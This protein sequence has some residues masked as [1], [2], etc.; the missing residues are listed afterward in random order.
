MAT[1]AGRTPQREFDVVVLGAT[2][3]TGR[4]V[5]ERLATD[6]G[7]GLR[8]AIAGR[9]ASKLESLTADLAT[10]ACGLPAA[11]VV[12]ATD[13]EGLRKLAE[14]TRVICT[15]VGPY[16]QHGA[17]VVAACAATGTHYCDLAGEAHWVRDMIDRYHEQAQRTG[18][19]IVPCC[20]F[21]SIP[22]DLGVW[23]LQS[24][25]SGQGR[26]A[27]EVL[28]LLTSMRG[29]ASG[30][31]LASIIGIASS[32]RKNPA[33][34][35]VIG[36]PHALDPD[37]RA[38][39]RDA[40]D[41]MGMARNSR[42]GVVTGPWLMAS[43]NRR[44]V[45]RS[46]ALLGHQYGEAFRYQEV[47]SRPATIRGTAQAAIGTGLTLGLLAAAAIPPLANMLSRR[48]PAGSGPDANARERGR[49][50]LQVVAVS[51]PDLPMVTVSDNLDPGYGSTSKMLS[52]SALCLA[53]DD[54]PEAA[55]LL[56]PAS[57]MGQHLLDR[58]QPRG[59]H[60]EV[61]NWGA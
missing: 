46:N 47:M 51:E 61:G 26:K 42:L 23:L 57:A 36:N 10:G 12:D 8:W 55:G 1:M 40:S 25:L 21:D 33:L 22:S 52:Q 11:V 41:Q 13:E 54:L 37:P 35:R 18:A 9:S 24:T 45:H 30:G 31:T 38:S 17:P 29:T 14:R 34:R 49:F 50:C 2:G 48:V 15:T 16:A 19:K 3:F 20:G 27:S 56:T 60:F 6:G 59:P 32:V 58:L 43:I 53:L 5:A 4:L 44:V 28:G 7:P 39:P